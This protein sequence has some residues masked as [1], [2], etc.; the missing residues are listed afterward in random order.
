M[1]FWSMNMSLNIGAEI[2]DNGKKGNFEV[3]QEEFI[4][5]HKE[6]PE[7]ARARRERERQERNRR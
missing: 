5:A 1:L 7:Q 2:K 6:T 3:G 4:K